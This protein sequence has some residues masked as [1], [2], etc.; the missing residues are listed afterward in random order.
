MRP[1]LRPGSH[2]GKRVKVSEV[3]GV[4]LT[5]YQCSPGLRVPQHSH[6]RAYFKLILAGGFAEKYDSRMRQCRPSAV[7][8]HPAGELHSEQAGS[9]GGRSFGVEFGPRLHHLI[10]EHSA[11]LLDRPAEFEGGPVAW[12][13]FR[14]YDEFQTNDTF[15]SLA[16][17]GLTLELLATAARLPRPG[18]ASTA[19]AWLRRA[20]E[21]LQENF[22]SHLT[23]TALAGQ[24]HVHPVHL[25]RA[26]RCHTGCSVGEFVRRR[27]GRSGTRAGA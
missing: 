25:A 3:G 9:N 16:V 7:L 8:F 14:L 23:L 4:I 1:I 5:D 18:A 6:E 12:L 21:I 26:F 19:P 27:A 10:R 20:T 11:Y 2:Y 17:E 22:T 13:A 24:V 15:S